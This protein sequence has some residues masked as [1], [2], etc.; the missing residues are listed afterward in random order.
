MRYVFD[1]ECVCKSKEFKISI[2]EQKLPDSEDGNA[3]VNWIHS[4]I[5]CKC[6]EVVGEMMIDTE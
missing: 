1:V 4:V 6:E 5:C 2:Y 3:Q